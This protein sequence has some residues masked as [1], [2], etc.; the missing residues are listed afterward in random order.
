MTV[1]MV[2][3]KRYSYLSKTTVTRMCVINTI[4]VV[5]TETHSLNKIYKNYI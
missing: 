4:L 1:V 2:Y 3:D 5:H